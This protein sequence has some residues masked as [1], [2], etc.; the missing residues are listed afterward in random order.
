MATRTENLMDWLRDA[1]AMEQQAETML[2]GQSS[3]LEHYP[4]LK[5]RIDQH[6]E[7]TLGQQA[8]V[9][10]CIERLGD[11][12]SLA[13]E[14]LGKVAAVGQ[15]A[16]GALMTDEVVKGA[17]ASYA[18]ENTEAGLYTVIIEAASIAGDLE[19]KR[20]CETILKEELAMAQWLF[21]HLPAL[22]RAFIERSEAPGETARR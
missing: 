7:E 14:L 18:F 5:A 19:T 10:A 4:L 13:K 16:G 22:T 12:T 6:L 9:K 3:R 20:I 21:Q 2:K 15:A 1:Y 8:Q 11:S 17:V